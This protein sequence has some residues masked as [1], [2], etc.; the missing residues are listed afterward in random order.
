VKLAF[1]LSSEI[2]LRPVAYFWFLPELNARYPPLRM[3]VGEIRDSLSHFWLSRAGVNLQ[4]ENLVHL[5]HD[6]WT[7]FRELRRHGRNTDAMSVAIDADDL[8]GF[9]NSFSGMVLNPDLVVFPTP[10]TVGSRAI[11]GHH[12]AT[13][14]PSGMPVLA[15]AAWRGAVRIVR[16]LLINGAKVTMEA[17]VAAIASGCPEI[18]RLIDDHDSPF[19]SPTGPR[20]FQTAPFRFAISCVSQKVSEWCWL[21]CALSF[22]QTAIFRWFLE[23]KLP[24]PEKSY[25]QFG[26]AMPAIAAAS[27]LEAL[28]LFLDL[29][30]HVEGLPK[31][32]I[33]DLRSG[34]IMVLKLV[35][36][37]AHEELIE[38]FKTERRVDYSWITPRAKKPEV[39]K[40]D[41]LPPLL[42]AVASG[43]LSVL[44]L[45]WDMIPDLDTDYHCSAIGAAFNR[46][47]RDVATFLIARFDWTRPKVSFHAILKEGA[48]RGTPDVAEL[49]VPF[50]SEINDIREFILIAV[51]SGNFEL[52][53]FWIRWQQKQNNRSLHQ[54]VLMAIQTGDLGIARLLGPPSPELAESIVATACSTGFLAGVQYGFQYL[55]DAGRRSILDSSGSRSFVRSIASFFL[56]QRSEDRASFI[57]AIKVG[58]IERVKRILAADPTGDLINILTPRGT[59]LGVAAG[60]GNEELVRFL[61]SVPGI[62]AMMPNLEGETPFVLACRFAPPSI[63]QLIAD[64][65]GDELSENEY[66]VNMG[67]LGACMRENADVDFVLTPFFS[68][69]SCVDPNFHDG[70]P[71]PFLA[72]CVR[73]AN[74]LLNWLLTFP[75]VNVND[76]IESGE[77]GAI[78]ASGH[79]RVNIVERLLEHPGVDFELVDM[80]GD[81]ALSIACSQG[82]I[83]VMNLL[84]ASGR[85]NVRLFGARALSQAIAHKC[86]AAF[87][88]II[89]HPRLDVNPSLS[90]SL[91]PGSS[92]LRE[93]PL[94]T[95]VINN[96]NILE[97]LR[98]RSFNWR[99]SN[100]SAAVFLSLR[101]ERA[102]GFAQLA[103]RAARD[104]VIRDSNGESLVSAISAGGAWPF[105]Q[106]LLAMPAFD[107]AQCDAVECLGAVSRLGRLDRAASRVLSSIPHLDLNMPLPHGANGFP[108]NRSGE[109]AGPG[110]RRRIA[111]DGVPVFFSFCH[112]LAEGAPVFD[113]DR[114]GKHGETV[115]AHGFGKVAH[116]SGIDVNTTDR[117]GNTPVMCEIVSRRYNDLIY[118]RMGGSLTIRNENGDPGLEIANA[119]VKLSRPNVGQRG[120]Q[121]VGCWPSR[122]SDYVPVNQIWLN[123][124]RLR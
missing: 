20:D 12:S 29:R 123:T 120:T 47:F 60:N 50:M 100:A 24:N 15:Y 75:G 70:S 80:Y 116:L 28:L 21:F 4:R 94:L 109:I 65:C 99:L 79:G 111:S 51:G 63:W 81:S 95:A 72:A 56:Q 121:A 30:G 22:A 41:R 124:P 37:L 97:I 48:P 61:L 85:I 9:Q 107:P 31:A 46:D 92:R 44:E 25:D 39:P 88:A 54:V 27:N 66:E 16:H 26:W 119:R 17:G 67:F 7:H 102:D 1:E 11:V 101:R 34:H 86:D 106:C 49:L 117:H 57:P 36:D 55:S 38:A 68:R 62:D 122:Y 112:P 52:A 2:T 74:A 87:D 82:H 5:I 45:V 58:D 23:T 10:F 18:V 43:D 113:L 53:K 73:P 103:Q 8:D 35:R 77:T 19:N 69:F 90:T 89:A 64:F 76:R 71:S 42:S 33:R 96:R 40:A 59:A 115:V 13:D 84:L 108:D 114:R 83:S 6:D 14:P 3:R 105:L 93:T 91:M 118:R 110:W 78:L 32:S 98:H 104:L